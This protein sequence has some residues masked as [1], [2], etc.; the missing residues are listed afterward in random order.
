MGRISSPVPIALDTANKSEL[1]CRC[2]KL[3]EL[4]SWEFLLL[5]FFQEG[6]K[7]TLLCLPAPAKILCD[8]IN[9]IYLTQEKCRKE[10]V[11]WADG[12]M[13]KSLVK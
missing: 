5:Q 13:L 7:I 10:K 8:K 9:Q 12:D 2:I 1:C 4:L 3:K 6:R 11:M